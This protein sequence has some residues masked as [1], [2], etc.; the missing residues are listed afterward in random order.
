MWAQEASLAAIHIFKDPWAFI[1]A[2]LENG[3]NQITQAKGSVNKSYCMSL[4][5]VRVQL[6]QK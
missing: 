1:F 6:Q 4:H 5:I 2:G 3:W